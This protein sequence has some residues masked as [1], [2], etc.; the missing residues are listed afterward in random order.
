MKIGERG[1]G[2]QP[3]YSADRA[4]RPGEAPGGGR[5][6]RRPARGTPGQLLVMVMRYFDFWRLRT[7]S[8]NTNRRPLTG[9]ES[10]NSGPW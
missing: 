8:S 6:V 2:V 7:Q 10:L 3:I 9:L 1:G 5:R 4:P